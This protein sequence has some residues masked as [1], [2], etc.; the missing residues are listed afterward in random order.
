MP[1]TRGWQGCPAFHHPRAKVCRGLVEY[2]LYGESGTGSDGLFLPLGSLSDFRAW[3]AMASD[4]VTRSCQRGGNQH[5]RTGKA[6]NAADALAHF[7][8]IAVHR[9]SAARRFIRLKNA[10]LN[11]AQ[12]IIPQGFAIRAQPGFRVMFGAAVY[13]NHPGD[14]LL[15]SQNGLLVFVGLGF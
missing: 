5:A 7:R 14:G 11:A 2:G 6:H 3:F 8:A 13:P 4:Q 12:G 15:L 10:A 1:A 9:A